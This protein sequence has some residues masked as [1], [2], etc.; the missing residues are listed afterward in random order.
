MALS[1]SA[2]LSRLLCANRT[3]PFPRAPPSLLLRWQLQNRATCPSRGLGGQGS[4]TLLDGLV[5]RVVE[6]NTGALFRLVRET[7]ECTSTRQAP[8]EPAPQPLPPILK[9]P[10]FPRRSSSPPAQ[11]LLRLRLSV[12]LVCPLQP[13]PGPAAARVRDH[14]R[15]QCCEKSS[16]LS[17]PCCSASARS[18]A[19][20]PPALPLQCASLP[21][22]GRGFRQSAARPLQTLRVSRLPDASWIRRSE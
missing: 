2:F 19:T 15:N 13:A 14:P 5:V 8:V 1:M 22:P 10:G 3:V 18:G 20:S 9:G 16:P 11:L 21:T 7:A 17:P 4:G 12:F 6:G